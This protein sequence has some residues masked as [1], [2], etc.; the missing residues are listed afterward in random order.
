MKT[1]TASK[2]SRFR[3][4]VRKHLKKSAKGAVSSAQEAPDQ[5]LLRIS[6]LKRILEPSWAWRLGSRQRSSS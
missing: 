6:D 4:F 5:D 1:H 2:V 3:V